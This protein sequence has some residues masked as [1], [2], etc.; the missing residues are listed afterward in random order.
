MHVNLHWLDL[1]FKLVSMVHNCLYHKA[2]QYFMDYC[3]WISDVASR[4]HLRSA[5]HCAST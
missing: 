1:K 2:H 3:I 4:R 5:R